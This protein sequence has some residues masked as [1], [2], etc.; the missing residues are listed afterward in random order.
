MIELI[1]IPSVTGAPECIQAMQKLAE[2]GKRFGFSHE[3]DDFCISI[4]HPGKQG[5]RELGILGHLDVVPPGNGWRYS[6]FQAIEKDGYVIGRGSCD[7]KGPVVMS[8]Y[9]MRF[10]KDAAIL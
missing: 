9:A 3:M 1:R 8:L 7:N 2:Y 10:L 4:V 5:H 6:P